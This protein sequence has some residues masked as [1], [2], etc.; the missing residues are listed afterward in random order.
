MKKETAKAIYKEVPGWMKKVLVDEFG[1]K[2]FEKKEYTEIKTLDDVVEALPEPYLIVFNNTDSPDEI[3]YKKLKAVVK[4]INQ[5][6]EPDWNNTNQ[7][8][9][10]P[11]FI[12]SSGFGF[13][14][15][16]YDYGGTNAAVGS[17]LCFETEEKANYAGTQFLELYKE[18][19]TISK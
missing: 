7:R 9:W 13:S 1:E 12:L 19:L 10:W 17:R 11:Y 2:T 3:A 14:Y 4:A 16:Y 5:A 6:W 18:F 8:K 15:S